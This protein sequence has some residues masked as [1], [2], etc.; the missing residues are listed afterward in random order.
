MGIVVCLA[1]LLGLVMLRPSPFNAKHR[2]DFNANFKRIVSIALGA[3]GLWNAL[4]GVFAISGFWSVMSI[5]SGIA[6]VLAAAV[7][8]RDQTENSGESSNA[9]N[10][11]ILVLAICFL[12]YAVTLIQLN[13]GY[14]ILR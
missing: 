1:M 3:L 13:L 5:V 11:I 2:V 6:M 9:E 4:F 10:G 7:I 8:V 12:V 14:A